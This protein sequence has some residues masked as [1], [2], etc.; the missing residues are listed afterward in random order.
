MFEQS[1][2]DLI[3]CLKSSNVTEVTQVSIKFVEASTLVWPLRNASTKRKGTSLPLFP[4]P[5]RL[6]FAMQA[7]K[8]WYF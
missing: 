8:M 6:P 5:T 1:G 4:S 7:T 2:E 3:K